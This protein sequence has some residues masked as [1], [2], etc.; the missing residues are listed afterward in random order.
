MQRRSVEVIWSGKMADG[1]DMHKLI[2][3]VRVN[4]A[5]T[6]VDSVKKLSVAWNEENLQSFGYVLSLEKLE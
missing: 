6:I 5:S 2:L 3:M 1:G 4:A